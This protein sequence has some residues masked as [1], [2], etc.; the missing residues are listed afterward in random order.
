MR[1]VLVFGS[2]DIIHPGHVAF[3]RAAKRYG[4]RL[5]VVVNRD[6]AYRKEKGRVP[7]FSERERLALVASLRDVS[8]A[9]LGDRPGSWTVIRRLRPDVIGVGY[10]QR[11]D[12]PG[13]AAQLMRLRKPP[14]IVKIQRFNNRKHK[15]SLIKKRIRDAERNP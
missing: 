15:S 8:R 11:V 14:K 12:H 5:I 9:Y 4:D 10:D 13:L 2:F 7:I 1:T 3:L 6:A